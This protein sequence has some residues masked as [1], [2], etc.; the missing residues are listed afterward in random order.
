MTASCVIL[1]APPPP[2]GR[3][4]G[5]KLVGH[6]RDPNIASPSPHHDHERLSIGVQPSTFSPI[7]QPWHLRKPTDHSFDEEPFIRRRCGGS[8]ATRS[9]SVRPRPSESIGSNARDAFPEA[10]MNPSTTASSGPRV[11][12][13]CHESPGQHPTHFPSNTRERQRETARPAAPQQ[14]GHAPAE[15]ASL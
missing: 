3:L 9:W 5:G 6:L 15:I 2:G 10:P 4:M 8:Q 13:N 7:S 1:P 14:P 12:S 11:E